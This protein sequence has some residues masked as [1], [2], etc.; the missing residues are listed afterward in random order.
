MKIAS[1]CLLLIVISG[2]LFGQN[3]IG[4]NNNEI[5]KF[6]KENRKEMNISNVRNS[7]FNYLKYSDNT[8]RQTILFFLSPDSVCQNVR[9]ICDT[10][11][12]S[13][14][15]SELNSNF[16]RIGDDRWIDSHGGKN[17][18]IKF[19]DEKWSCTITIERE[20]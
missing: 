16:K 5:R 11:M 14:K 20:K 18:I 3:L 10:T 13:E 9:V 1:L 15:I 19:M 17:Y 4:Y 6:M 7:M 8:D 12:K 2:S